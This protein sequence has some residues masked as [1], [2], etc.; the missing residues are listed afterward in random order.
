[1]SLLAV[2]VLWMRPDFRMWAC[3]CWSSE[4]EVAISANDRT[5]GG[6]KLVDIVTETNGLNTA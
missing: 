2:E 6:G 4:M 3:A 1:M 5:G